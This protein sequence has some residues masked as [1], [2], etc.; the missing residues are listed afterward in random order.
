MKNE[1]GR[2]TTRAL[3]VDAVVEIDKESVREWTDRDLLV[4]LR[5]GENRGM[6]FADESM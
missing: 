1:N 6:R 4:A 3:G 2:F 5:P